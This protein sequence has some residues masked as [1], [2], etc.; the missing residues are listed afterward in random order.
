MIWYLNDLNATFP[1]KQP[2]GVYW[3]RVDIINLIW[4]PIKYLKI[5]KPYDTTILDFSY[6]LNKTSNKLNK[7]YDTT[8]KPL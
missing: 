7:P 8:I 1:I 6:W 2:F 4:S 3:S 5:S